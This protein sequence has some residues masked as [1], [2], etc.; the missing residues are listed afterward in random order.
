MQCLHPKAML[1]DYLFSIILFLLLYFHCFNIFNFT[2]YFY[3]F[4]YPNFM[5]S[6]HCQ[7]LSKRA[8]IRGKTLNCIITSENESENWFS[9]ISGSSQTNCSQELSTALLKG[10]S[11]TWWFLLIPLH[12]DLHRNFPSPEPSSMPAQN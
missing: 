8:K 9:R 1:M 11:T 4:S 2:V 7:W 6:K 3:S 12:R 10:N 5:A